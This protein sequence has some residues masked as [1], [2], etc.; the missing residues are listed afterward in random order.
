VLEHILLLIR[1]FPFSFHPSYVCTKFKVHGISSQQQQHNNRFVY[2]T[3]RKCR[4]R[5]LHAW[6]FRRAG[7]IHLNLR[8]RHLSF[9]S[10]RGCVKPKAAL[11]CKEETALFGI[12]NLLCAL[13]NSMEMHII[14]QAA[15]TIVEKINVF[16]SQKRTKMLFQKLD[17][18]GAFDVI[19][20]CS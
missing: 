14:Q 15:Y 2:S 20:Q 18:Y 11:R 19:I 17:V 10:G 16:S 5:I 9:L 1:A 12:V 4:G 7:C 6:D 8:R 3:A 13:L